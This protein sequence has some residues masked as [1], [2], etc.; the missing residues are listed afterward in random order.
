MNKPEYG[1]NRWMPSP[2]QRYW[3]AEWQKKNR[4]DLFRLMQEHPELP[5]VPMV[6]SEVVAGDEYPLWLGYLGF[7]KLD[8]YLLT[9]ERV[10]IRSLDDKEDVL[11]QGLGWDEYKHL[12]DEEATQA[13]K[14]VKWTEAIVVFVITGGK[15]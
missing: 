2:N 3:Y 8:G 13:Y 5:V 12:S 7:S 4:D 9:D 14:D 1:S 11:T 15:K 10:L 6:D